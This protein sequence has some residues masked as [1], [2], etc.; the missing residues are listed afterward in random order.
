MFKNLSRE[1]KL[2]IAS[3]AIVSL[4]IAGHVLLINRYY[5]TRS[6]L[7]SA[8]IEIADIE[9]DL[10]DLGNPRLL[11]QELVEASADL[12]RLAAQFPFRRSVPETMESVI[13]LAEAHRL[14]VTSAR[15]QSGDDTVFLFA[16][17]AT[18]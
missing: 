5:E 14:V 15:S 3:V 6:V 16:M 18:R 7:D 13:D 11:R 17:K 8:S 2:I 4:S 12:E 1:L 10:V 9:A